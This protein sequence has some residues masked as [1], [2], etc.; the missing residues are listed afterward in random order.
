[1]I[2][3][4]GTLL[5]CMEYAGMLLTL[6]IAYSSDAEA[7]NAQKSDKNEATLIVSATKSTLS[8]CM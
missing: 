7:D 8:L 6:P 2:L 3:Y 5:Q 1:M 4:L